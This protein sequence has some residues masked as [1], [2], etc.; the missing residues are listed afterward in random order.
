M[1]LGLGLWQLRGFGF[2]KG[3]R[4]LGL[5]TTTVSALN[6][7]TQTIRQTCVKACKQTTYNRH[8]CIH[9][10]VPGVSS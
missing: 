9:A 6:I 4:R 7:H 1:F 5:P 10:W 2:Y 8:V 3:A